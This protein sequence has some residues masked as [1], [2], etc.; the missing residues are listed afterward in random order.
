M[1]EDIDK[2]AEEEP[3]MNDSETLE[4]LLSKPKPRRRWPRILLTVLLLG[5]VGLG[6]YHLILTYGFFSK[7]RVGTLTIYSKP[8]GAR[9]YLDGREIGHTPKTIPK[10]ESGEHV[11]KLTLNGFEEYGAVIHVL[12]NEPT[13]VRT[14][15][16]DIQPLRVVSTPIRVASLNKDLIVKA[17]IQDNLKVEEANLFYRS[18][19]TKD[20]ESVRM[21]PVGDSYQATIPASYIKPNGVEYYIKASDGRNVAYFSS[22][23]NPQRV[24]VLAGAAAA[25]KPIKVAMA[26]RPAKARGGLG[27]LKISSEPE[28]ARIL[29]NGKAMGTTPKHISRLK[30]GTHK[31]VLKK[32]GFCDWT[33][34]IKISKG[35]VTQIDAKLEYPR[36][37]IVV[38]STPSGA[39]VWMNG[40]LRGKTP[41]EIKEVKAWEPHRIEVVMPGY[42]EW[43]SM[44]FT[45]P[46][47]T[48]IINAVLKQAVITH[49]Y[50]TSIP[51]GA[52]LY[53]DG[54]IVGQTPIRGM[55][56]RV[57]EHTLKVEKEGFLPLEKEIIAME[58]RPSFVNF[59]L[60]R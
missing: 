44:V 21:K 57:G 14:T 20:Y 59:Y 19:G 37:T 9:I 45:D 52:D 15:L 41:V 2:V 5:G 23:S 30:A 32:S 22:P 55:K 7:P 48:T 16:V 4:T 24:R 34:E 10:I 56:I 49:L 31:L 11:L 60:E 50:V 18:S 36:G 3:Y 17:S 13:E 12:P 47:D 51:Q 1:R 46:G 35:E 27:S 29:I 6:G 40:R 28:G 38:K 42:Y 58:G 54:R 39:R 53:I 43:S 33:R 8:P 26:K 25:S